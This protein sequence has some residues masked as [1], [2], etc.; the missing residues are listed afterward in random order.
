MFAL[1]DT[2]APTSSQRRVARALSASLTTARTAG[3][4]P[5]VLWLGNN[6][7]TTGPSRVASRRCAPVDALWQAKGRAEI[8]AIGREQLA[9]GLASY[10]VLG[11]VDWSCGA[12]ELLFQRPGE[13]GLPW[14]MPSYNYVV[15][16]DRDGG[17]EVASRC[18]AAA[19]ATRCELAPAAPDVAL[20]LWLLDTTPWRA[21]EAPGS[22]VSMAE[23]RALLSTLAAAPEPGPLR[24][25][26]THHPIETAGPHGLGGR[27]PDSAYHYTAPAL[28]EALDAGR[29]AGVIS[30]HDR[31][32]QVTADISDGVKRSSRH[33][34]GSPV[35]QV[36]SGASARP[37]SRAAGSRR[38]RWYRGQALIPDLLS[39]HAGYAELRIGDATIDALL[40]AYRRGRWREGHVEIP[41]DRPPHPAE[42]PSPNLQPCL[43]CDTRPDWPW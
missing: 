43:G 20:E 13:R 1:G 23:Q 5:I 31:N 19:D 40:H 7:G 18:E 10:A 41:R 42:T 30:A 24:V 34:L 9:T 4:A 35:F 2:G 8:G 3:A 29:F 38:W 15:R 33:W 14:V 36:V 12:P 21:P 27:Y 39:T 16:V 6:T 17:H 28:R 32:L 25:L 26:V 22:A 37:D 11:P